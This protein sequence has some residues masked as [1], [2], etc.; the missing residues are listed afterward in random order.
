M[1]TRFIDVY[2]ELLESTKEEP[3][4][5]GR[6]YSLVIA[7]VIHGIFYTVVF[8]IIFG[9]LN[10]AMAPDEPA[11]NRSADY[12]ELQQIHTEAL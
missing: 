9:L 1:V 12:Y 2:I 8:T 3:T 10:A 4:E 11:T 5:L 7:L 6:L